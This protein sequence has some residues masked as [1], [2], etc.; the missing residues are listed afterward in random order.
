MPNNI[1]FE[2]PRKEIGDN[3]LEIINKHVHLNTI[4]MV[5][6]TYSMGD[7]ITSIVDLKKVKNRGVIKENTGE[8]IGG[9]TKVYDAI[10]NSGLKAV[11]IPGLHRG[12]K[13]LDPRFSALY[14][15]MASSEKV[16]I[17]YDAFTSIN[18]IVSA[19]NIIVSDISS[20]TVTIGIMDS[21][22]IGAF[23]ACIGA[24]GTHHGPLDLEFIRLIDE[25]KIKANEAF[26]TSGIRKIHPIEEIDELIY[27]QDVKSKIAFDSMILSVKMEIFNFLAVF[28]PDAIIITGTM[29][30][31]DFFFKELER[32][33][34]HISPV[35]KLDNFSAAR[36][37]AKIAKA[38]DEGKIDILGIPIE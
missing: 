20:N 7:G 1:R 27:L 3:I 38:V 35:Y 12:I 14:S 34:V 13:S 23:D 32:Q 9:G 21:R 30:N 24:L 15:H 18:E 25:G 17:G 36:G 19:E 29:G 10:Y 28:H 37:S 5:G 4:E 8:F 2:I 6:L 31:N 11:L 33:L 22:F 26:Y 16:S